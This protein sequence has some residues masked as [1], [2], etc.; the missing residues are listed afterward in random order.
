MQDEIARLDQEAHVM[1]VFVCN[2][3]SALAHQHGCTID[4]STGKVTPTATHTPTTSERLDAIEQ[5]L[6]TLSNALNNLLIHLENTK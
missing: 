4:L 1:E 6:S 3:L 5:R 2:A